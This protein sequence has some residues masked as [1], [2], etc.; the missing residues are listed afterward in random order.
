MSTTAP[1]IL[2][3]SRTRVAENSTSSTKPPVQID[4]TVLSKPTTISAPVRPR[5]MRSSPSRKGVPGA[6]VASVVRC[7][8]WSV[9]SVA[10]MRDAPLLPGLFAGI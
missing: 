6:S 8:S 1:S 7:R 3:S 4:S 9:G 10:A 2:D 5:R